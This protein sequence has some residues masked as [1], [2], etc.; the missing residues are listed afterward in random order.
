MNKIKKD[1]S[2]CSGFTLLEVLIAMTIF[3]VAL[4]ALASMQITGIKGNSIAMS[5]TEKVAAGT[6]IISQILAL[7]GD[8]TEGLD[9]DNDGTVDFVNFLESNLTNESWTLAN[10]IDKNGN[11]TVAI[12]VDKAPPV[13]YVDEFGFNQTWDDDIDDPDLKLTQVNVRI[14]NSAGHVL[15][16]KRIMKRRY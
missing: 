1:I 16:E 9:T 7:S 2:K 12:D 3:A 5:V 14:Y 4:L 15:L 10:P 6:G 8:S 13:P 11:W